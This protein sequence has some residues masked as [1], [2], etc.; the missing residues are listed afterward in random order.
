MRIDLNHQSGFIYGSSEPPSLNAR[1]NGLIDR[2]LVA[3]NEAQPKRT[4]P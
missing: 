1:L 2:A 3:Q 4:Y